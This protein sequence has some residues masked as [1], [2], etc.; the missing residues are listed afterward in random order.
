M[1]GV[2]HI[3]HHIG[4]SLPLCEYVGNLD[5]VATVQAIKV[6]SKQFPVVCP[7]CLAHL[8]YPLVVLASLDAPEATYNRLGKSSWNRTRVEHDG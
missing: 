2:T 3:I 7:E 8:D 1:G 6:Y 4:R 5:N